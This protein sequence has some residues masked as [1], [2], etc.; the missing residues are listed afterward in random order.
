MWKRP[1][2]WKGLHSFV[3]LYV[4]EPT[5]R[6]RT[7]YTSAQL[8][9]L[10]KE[11]HFNRYLCRPRRI[12]MAA[13]LNLTERQI[14]I[15]FQN[16]RMKYKK[17]Q[18][19]KHSSDKG[20][21]KLDGNLSGSESDSEG[22]Y[23]GGQDSMSDCKSLPGT[24]SPDPSGMH[25]LP[26]GGMMSTPQTQTPSPVQRSQQSQQNMPHMSGPY[27]S[28]DNNMYHPP[29]SSPQCLKQSGSP[30]PTHHGNLNGLN[31][32][33][34]NMNMNMHNSVPNHYLHMNNN[35]HGGYNNNNQHNPHYM[36]SY[37]MYSD[38][39]P[40]HEDPDVG[41]MTQGQMLPSPSMPCGMGGMNCYPQ[42]SYEY[43]PKLTHL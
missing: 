14:K 16:R 8:V 28:H 5:K 37:Q 24:G 6:A 26:P 31:H 7:A 18:R 35:S 20:L 25:Q 42:G 13:L 29:Q 1:L 34:N 27:S 38:M 2:F 4:S 30:L 40:P 17:E 12:E 23:P 11:F 41:Q 33:G 9:E 15:W 10:E 19:Q 3:F 39:T 43:I 32:M 36:T 22:S 21:S